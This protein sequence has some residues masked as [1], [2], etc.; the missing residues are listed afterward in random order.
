MLP[1][2]WWVLAVRK[3]MRLYIDAYMPSSATCIP[4]V[5]SSILSE[6][7]V[8]GS[9]SIILE[10]ETMSRSAVVYNIIFFIVVSPYKL[11]S[12][13]RVML[14]TGTYENPVEPLK[15]CWGFMPSRW[16]KVHMLSSEM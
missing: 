16:V 1:K 4:S 5:L 2:V 10:Q 14:R 13:P 9:V 3:S 8:V 15:L 7:S 11:S 6:D 12:T